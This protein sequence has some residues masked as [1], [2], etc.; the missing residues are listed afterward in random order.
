MSRERHDSAWRGRAND[1]A[2]LDERSVQFHSDLEPDGGVP[3]NRDV[4]SGRHAWVQVARGAVTLN[5]V[6]LRE[7]DGAALSDEARIELR[8]TAEAEVLVFDLA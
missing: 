2:P 7:G 3:V 1:F 6:E 4:A 5:G 8:A